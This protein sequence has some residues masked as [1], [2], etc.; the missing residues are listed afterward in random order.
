MSKH[1]LFT[2]G[3]LAARY[4]SAIN[5]VI[6]ADAL[7]VSDELFSQ[8][9]NETDGIWSQVDG[10]IVKL[11]L[12]EPTAEQLQAQTNAEARA[13]LNSTGWVVEKMSEYQ[14]IGKPVDD[15]L[16]KYADILA[17][18]QEARDAIV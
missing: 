6:P 3:I 12:P 16:I 13:Y 14:L 8:T 15:L 18:R 4:D 5:D 11:P 1:I 10:D 7:E 17:A 9:I 2:D